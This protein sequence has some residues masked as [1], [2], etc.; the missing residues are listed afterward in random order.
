MF[1]NLTYFKQYECERRGDPLEGL[2][3]DNPD[4]DITIRR[5]SDGHITKG[6]FSFLNSIDSDLVYVFCLSNS[7]TNELYNEFESDACIEITNPQEFIKRVLLKVKRL[8]S[9]HKVGLLSG[10]V[11]YYQPNEAAEFNIHDPYKLPFSKDIEFISQDEY[12]IVFGTRKA[13]KIEK[14][15]VANAKYDFREEAMKGTKKEKY[16]KIGSIGDIANI[17]YKNT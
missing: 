9:C 16:I 6:D 13:F 1:R 14:S 11:N 12:R 10:N 4:N 5:Q 7:L 15:I 17:K 8:V 2:H 3:R